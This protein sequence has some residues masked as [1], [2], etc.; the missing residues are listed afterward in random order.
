M[1]W[2]EFT[3]FTKIPMSESLKFFIIFIL[4]K[5]KHKGI[6]KILIRFKRKFYWRVETQKKKKIKDVWRPKLA[7]VF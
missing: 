1:C 2:L 3:E 7:R 6:L 5:N 4:K